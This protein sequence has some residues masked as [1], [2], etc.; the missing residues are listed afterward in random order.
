ME[1]Y[2]TRR[3]HQALGMKFP[4]ELYSPSPRPYRGLP[5]VRYP[6]CD[7]TLT[8]THC[9]RICLAKRKINFSKVFSGVWGSLSSLIALRASR[10]AAP[11]PAARKHR[12]A[13]IARQRRPRHTRPPHAPT[14]RDRA[15]AIA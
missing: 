12:P 2:N 11:A 8:V 5:D 1:V 13:R 15:H 3:P 14:S 6:L 4:G 9:G 10:R 7:R